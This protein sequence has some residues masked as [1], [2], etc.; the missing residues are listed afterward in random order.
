MKQMPDVSDRQKKEAR[1]VKKKFRSWASLMLAV[2]LV[3]TLIPVNSV[4]A[5]GDGASY[6]NFDNISMDSKNPTPE[7]RGTIQINGTFSGIVPSSI[8]YDIQRIDSPGA[9]GEGAKPN[10]DPS[11]NRFE[12][13]NV[14]LYQG[15]N[16]IIISGIDTIEGKK[17]EINGYVKFTDAP[18]IYEVALNDG[19]ILEDPETSPNPVIT[20]NQTVSISVKA[21]NS[22]KSMTVNGVS[23]YAGGGDAYYSAGIRLN[24][25]TNQLVIVAKSESKEQT[26]IRQ[27]VYHPAGSVTLHNPAYGGQS[28]D[29]SAV[30]TGNKPMDEPVT[31][32][33]ILDKGNTATKAIIELYGPDSK[34]I[35]LERE[36]VTLSSGSVTGDIIKYRFTT[37]Q[38]E[39]PKN[40]EY[41]LQ[42]TVGGKSRQVP[43]TFRDSNSPVITDI[44]RLLP[45]GSG[46]FNESKFPEGGNLT[47]SEL[48]LY[49]SVKTK[50]GGTVSLKSSAGSKGFSATSNGNNNFTITSLP[51]GQQ[52]LIIEVHDGAELSDS[53]HL[54]ITFLSAPY[55]EVDELYNNKVFKDPA[56]EFTRISGR[57]VNFTPDSLIVR[58]NGNQVTLN[59][60]NGDIDS[61][62]VFSITAGEYPSLFTLLPGPNTITISTPNGTPKTEFTVLYFSNN[63]SIIKGITPFLTGSVAFPGAVI[64]E[65]F[66]ETGK[67]EYTT[68]EK[69]LGLT[70]AVESTDEITINRSYPSTGLYAA[71]TKNGS[72]WTLTGGSLLSEIG[73]ADHKGYYTI[74][75]NGKEV[76]VTLQKIELPK[77]GLQAITIGSR[78]QS[79]TVSETI[80]ITREIPD[81]VVLSPKLPQESVVKQN[82]IKVSIMADGADEVLIGKEKMK[83]SDMNSGI[84]R[85]DVN[86]LKPG[87]N[88]IKYTIVTGKE[89]KNRSFEVTYIDEVSEGAQYKASLS[90]TGKVSVFKGNVVINVPKGTVLRQALSGPSAPTI[91]LFNERDIVFGIANQLDGRTIKEYN[92]VG[93]VSNGVEQDGKLD[94]INAMDRVSAQ[95]RPVDHFGYASN[96]YWIDAGYFDNLTSNN[97]V[98]LDKYSLTEAD[99]PYTTNGYNFTQ[100]LTA[101]DWME[102]TQPGTITLKY[103]SKLVNAASGNLGVGWLNPI[104]GTWTNIGGKVDEKKKTVTAPFNGFGYYAVM[105]LRYS[106]DDVIGHKTARSDIELMLARGIMKASYPNNFGVYDEMT[107]GEFATVLV[108]ALN[109]PLDY[110]T[111]INK[112]TFDD[113]G[114]VITPQ[115]DYRYIETAARKGIIRGIAP[116]VF[117]P[118]GVL[119]REEAANIIA[120]AME[121]K[122]GDVEKDKLKL[123]KQFTDTNTIK[124]NY[125]YPAILA[126]TKA[127]IITGIPNSLQA[128]EKKQTYRFDPDR[129][130]NRAD[131]AT[132]VK[133]IMAKLKVL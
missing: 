52:S 69:S 122:L 44:F 65:A 33:I 127:G 47:V 115:W 121:L 53:R 39:L 23:M 71:F 111:N 103:D 76:I 105:S 4:S 93:E 35:P 92:R 90:K 130:L 99:H 60:L 87:K 61:K 101:K 118:A 9:N 51:T 38:F 77:T 74:T 31:G 12:L 84:F 20:T 16:K 28:I 131:T 54:P 24:E 18:A 125:S 86:N 63:T 58:V 95:L 89:K 6:F 37:Q 34:V 133:R 114:T 15:V 57:V 2:A 98:D 120:R 70:F 119:S 68:Y 104:N 59:K 81:A 1:N 45:N 50:N 100:R 110:E 113:V 117:N 49:I 13:I 3:F 36:V 106:Y 107:R 17:R 46:G 132:I 40:G 75:E 123:Q 21:A 7:N 55:I 112:L 72:V 126:V 73:N 43:F 42:V 85:L 82:F 80:E 94:V 116:R 27:I 26:I 66:K 78:L 14:K 96:L 22:S 79:T 102:P 83:K 67:L 8:T 30:I 10:I 108:R 124:S 19:T 5:A 48:P 62:G 91:N 56:S 109:I 11:N 32:D 129:V 64:D 41:V 97:A 88:T 29:H 128:G 25:G